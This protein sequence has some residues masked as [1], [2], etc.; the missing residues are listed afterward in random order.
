MTTIPEFDRTRAVLWLFAAL[1]AAAL[2][3]V[4]WRYVGTLVLGL[5]VYYVT[6][7]VFVR[8]DRRVPNRTLSTAIAILA[9][10]LPVLLL[11]G[12]T[13]AVAVQELA[14]LAES[15]AFE[16]VAVA[17]EPYLDL[18]QLRQQVEDGV[19]LLLAEP[20][21]LSTLDP[22]TLNGLLDGLVAS[23]ATVGNAAVQLFIVLV[24]T[25]YLLRDG[26]RIAAWVRRT[27]FAESDEGTVLLAYF[28]AVDR[29]LKTVY[30]GNILNALV[31][32]L[33]GAAVY[34]LLNLGAPPVVPIPN[35]VLLGLLTG[36][37]SLVPVVGMKLVWV[38]MALLMAVDSLVSDP[39]TL[40]FPA[41]FALVSVVV[42]DYIPD[43]LLRPYVS[44][45]SLHVGAV[46]LAYIL[47]PLL[48][49]WYGIFLGPLVL[50]L[51]FEF[52]RIVVPWLVRPDRWPAVLG[53][54]E[55]GEL[56]VEVT[57]DEPPEAPVESDA[58]DGVGGESSA[59]VDPPDES[60]GEGSGP[61]AS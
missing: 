55:A 37:A 40:W 38:P 16:Q 32:G 4:G 11:V 56:P 36:V 59:E 7:P 61:P 30:F 46:M 44:G 41:V 24:I 18:A 35:P 57:A 43:Q 12:W 48:F 26:D 6:R 20:E 39:E 2:A 15:A 13:V 25:F 33:L 28:V 42:V 19:E 53:P 45:R 54:V 22:R 60:P 58:P 27:F 31:T 3:F 5:F 1:L 52:A 23:L 10:T 51:V 14:A 34:T 21:R 47:G 50:V 49:G 9:V 17:L 29:D 8:I